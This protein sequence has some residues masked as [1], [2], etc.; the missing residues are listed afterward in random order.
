VSLIQNHLRWNPGNGKEIKIWEDHFSERGVLSSIPALDHFRLW[1]T[2]IGKTT[3][4]DISNWNKNGAW[5][6]WN[7]GEVPPSCE[8]RLSSSSWWSQ[9]LPQSALVKRTTEVGE[10]QGTQ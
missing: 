10:K 6:N 8:M 2:S 1:L 3:L 9:G 4:F 5:E 7:L